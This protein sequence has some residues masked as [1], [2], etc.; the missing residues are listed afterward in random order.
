[1]VSSGP[2]IHPTR[3]HH[4]IPMDR[5]LFTITALQHIGQLTAKHGIYLQTDRTMHITAEENGIRGGVMTI[6]DGANDVK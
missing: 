4:K 1:M 5:V 6:L 3:E 2:V